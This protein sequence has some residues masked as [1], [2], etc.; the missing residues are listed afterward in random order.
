MERYE[1]DL[2]FLS[3][4]LPFLSHRRVNLFGA[5]GE[6]QLFANQM[7]QVTLERIGICVGRHV[8]D[9][10]TVHRDARVLA[11]M[12]LCHGRALLIGPAK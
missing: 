8:A 5:P 7:P 10:Y 3:N 2:P 11:S 6:T 1:D 12:P 4:D 9:L